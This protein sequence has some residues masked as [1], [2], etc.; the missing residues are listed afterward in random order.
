M[1]FEELR[2]LRGY[3]Y[4]PPSPILRC[5][6]Y[7]F[8]SEIPQRLHCE[9]TYTPHGQNQLNK[10]ISISQARLARHHL[11]WAGRTLTKVISK[12]RP[13]VAGAQDEHTARR[14]FCRRHLYLADELLRVR[15]R[16]VLMRVDSGFVR[17]FRRRTRRQVKTAK[18]AR[19]WGRA[20]C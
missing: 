6:L 20:T 10:P 15:V 8:C 3:Q 2:V 19:I 17:G 4:E 13:K 11:I 14:R 5:L 12:A 7:E 9:S 18:S 16:M 1:I